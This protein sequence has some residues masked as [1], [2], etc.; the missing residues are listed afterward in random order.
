MTA[1]R[2]KPTFTAGVSA[3]ASSSCPRSSVQ[4]AILVLTFL[5]FKRRFF[6]DADRIPTLTITSLKWPPDEYQKDFW[7]PNWLRE[8]DGYPGSGH[9]SRLIAHKN[10]PYIAIITGEDD[11][12]AALKTV[13]ARYVEAIRDLL[14]SDWKSSDPTEEKP[15]VTPLMPT[16]WHDALGPV[17]PTPQPGLISWLDIWPAIGSAVGANPPTLASWNLSRQENGELPATVIMTAAETYSVVD[18]VASYSF[19]VRVP[20]SV[21]SYDGGFR[22]TVRSVTVERPA[23]GYISASEL[24]MNGDPDEEAY[25]QALL[26]RSDVGSFQSILG[27]LTALSAKDAFV[28]EN[29]MNAEQLL[30]PAVPVGTSETQVF[31]FALSSKANSAPQNSTQYNVRPGYPIPQSYQIVSDIE[32]SL[33]LKPEDTPISTEVGPLVSHGADPGAAEVFVKTPP[34]WIEADGQLYKYTLRRPSREDKVLEA[35]RVARDIGP[36]VEMELEDDGFEVR[37]CPDYVIADKEDGPGVKTVPLPGGEDPA[38]RRND[39]SAIMTYCHSLDFFHFMEAVGLPPALYAVRAQ[40]KVE[41]FYR[42]GIFPGP[43]RDGKTVNAQ[44][45][46][47]CAEASQGVQPKV[48]IRLALA[49]LNRWARPENPAATGSTHPDKRF[50]PLEPLGIASS[51]RWMLHEMGHYLIA[52]RLGKLEF[53]FAHSAGDALAAVWY[54]P[55]SRLGGPSDGLGPQFRGITYPFVFTTRR[56]DRSPLLGWAWYGALNRSV[57]AAPPTSC[58]TL[59]GYLSEQILSSTVFRLYLALGGD[60]VQDGKPDRYIRYRASFMTLFLL[61]RAIASFAQSPSKA[62]MLELAMEDASLLMNT[63]VGIPAPA[64]GTLDTTPALTAGDTWSGGISHKVV[65]WS[66]EAQGMF[67]EEVKQ[68]T[69]GP[70]RAAPVDVYLRDGRPEEDDVLGGTLHYGPGSYAPVSLDWTGER[71]WMVDPAQGFVL[72]NR[73]RVASGEVRLRMWLGI[74]TGDMTEPH[75]DLTNSIN[76]MLVV[77]LPPVPNLDPEST[78]VVG[79]HDDINVAMGQASEGTTFICLLE[80]S[81]DDD[82]ANSDPQALLAAEIPDQA[83]PPRQPRALTDLVAGDNNLG[84]M[85]L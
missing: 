39:F 25:I 21:T 73:G 52:A 76:W 20:M 35:Y 66:F 22:V 16:S 54:D 55:F 63:A 32:L 2:T 12:E 72:G 71:A 84:L 53:D 44:V 67:V 85:L 45:A 74:V 70:G 79:I 18:K 33:P 8:E 9:P 41:I 68:T 38:P 50:L 13:A 37:R 83:N 81:C 7:P 11:L 60:T 64:P 1:E 31:R 14:D 28:D 36:E 30:I 80:S 49:N 77:P 59:K 24:L 43:G 17:P 19:G 23:E 58:D 10:V 40:K 6:A 57:I 29:T 48:Q 15:V 3:V 26:A 62:E 82:L 51:G 46:F 65:R 56:H 61:V 4:N 78:E 34:G 69:N 42:Y 27:E 47:D 75:W 5:Q